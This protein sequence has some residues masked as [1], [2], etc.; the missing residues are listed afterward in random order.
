MCVGE[1]PPLDYP[2][3]FLDMGTPPRSSARIAP[4][5]IGMTPASIGMRP[6][7]RMRALGDV[8]ARAPGSDGDMS[9]GL[10]THRRGRRR[11]HRR[12]TAALALAQRD[13]RVALLEAAARLE[14]TG[15]GIQLSP[16]A[17]RIL[18]GLGLGERLAPQ[19]V[20]PEELR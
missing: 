11:R 9:R 12:L 6:D 20:V 13:F 10:L 18:I 14:E 2:H 7:R 8:T 16:N 19:V 1:T 17:S 5:S 15:A 4:R 3:V